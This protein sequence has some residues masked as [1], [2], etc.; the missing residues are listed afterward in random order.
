M[1][2]DGQR[3]SKESQR[4]HHRPTNA[5]Q[6]NRT[7]DVKQQHADHCN[8]QDVWHDVWSGHPD[9]NV[10]MSLRAGGIGSGNCRGMAVATKTRWLI[11]TREV[12]AELPKQP[13]TGRDL[14]GGNEYG[15]FIPARISYLRRRDFA[16]RPF[17]LRTA[18]ALATLSF[19]AFW[20]YPSS[21][22]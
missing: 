15:M 2:R 16:G 17:F 9:V 18:R 11:T 10:T 13:P 14:P 3:R 5:R 12:V 20:A 4:N 19:R 7:A 21:G 8:E 6:R 1:D 22:R